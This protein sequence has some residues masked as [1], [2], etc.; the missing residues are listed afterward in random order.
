[1]LDNR[2]VQYR[3]LNARAEAVAKA[4]AAVAE[5]SL[6][7]LAERITGLR[8]S[9]ADKRAEAEKI[10]RDQRLFSIVGSQVPYLDLWSDVEED[11]SS[12][13]TGATSALHNASL[14]LPI[15]GG[16]RV[17]CEEISEILNSA[18]QLLEPAS[19]CVQNLLPKVEEVD[20]VASNLAQV[21]ASERALIEECGNLLNQ[22]HH[23]QMREYSLRSHLMQLK[24]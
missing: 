4:K 8:E 11:Y 24:S 15:V 12:C 5:S 14:R 21:I 10:K 20:C 3:F 19:P 13:L 16:V 23:M 2:H 17:N 9:V 22:A 6:F 7:G 18:V 1:M